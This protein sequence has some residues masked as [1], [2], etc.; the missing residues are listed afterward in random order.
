MHSRTPT[1][2]RVAAAGYYRCHRDAHIEVI[3]FSAGL[4]DAAMQLY[5]TRDNKD[6]SLTDCFSFVVME[7]RHLTQAPTTDRHFRQA[8]FEAVL[9]SEPE[10]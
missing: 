4:I 6:W 8:G 2:R 1:A 5:G 9:L 7:Q 3:P 10:A